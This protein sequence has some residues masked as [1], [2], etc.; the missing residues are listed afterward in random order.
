MRA[1]ALLSIDIT[2]LTNHRLID[3]LFVNTK[4]MLFSLRLWLSVKYRRWRLIGHILRQ[5]CNNDW[6][7]AISWAPEGEKRR[8]RSKTTWRR[9]EEKERKEAGWNSWKET[10]TVAADQEKWRS[11]VKALCA[12]RHEKDR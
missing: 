8:G 4:A 9:T 6:N 10:R 3:R 12:T 1:H 7:I 5:D 11:S 2:S